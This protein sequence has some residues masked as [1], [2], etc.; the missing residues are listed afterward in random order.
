M[1]LFMWL[2][3]IDT[4]SI[5]VL[6]IK[7]H[8]GGHKKPRIILWR[9]G[10]PCS[11]GFPRSVRVLGTP[12]NQCTSWRHHERLCW[13]SVK[14]FLKTQCVCPLHDGWFMSTRP[15]LPTLH[16]VFSSFW[17]KKAWPLCPTLPIHH[18]HLWTTSLFGCFPWW[19][20]SSEGN[21]LLMWKRGNNKWWKH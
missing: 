21:I 11:R 7:S 8:K 3:S 10:F 1:F 2:R 6:F 5:T 17:P 9:S 16:W 12:L 15:H 19:K 18:S 14:F 20:K 13:A 4:I